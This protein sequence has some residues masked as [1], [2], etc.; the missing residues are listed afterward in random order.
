MTNQRGSKI[1]SSNPMVILGGVVIL[2]AMLLIA[3]ALALNASS[4]GIGTRI[5][6]ALNGAPVAQRAGVDLIQGTAVTITAVDGGIGDDVAYTINSTGGGEDLATTLGI[7]NITGANNILISSP[8]ALEFEDGGSA[9]NLR[10]IEGDTLT[11]DRT[12]TFNLNNT[13]S[14]LTIEASSSL[15]QDLTTDSATAAFATLTVNSLLASA[16]DS[17][18][19]GASGIAFSDLFLTSGAVISFGAGNAF[20]THS[21]G[22]LTI[23]GDMG[24]GITPS[25]VLHIKADIPGTIGDNAAGQLIIQNPSININTNVVITGYNSDISGNPDVQLWYLGSSSSSNANIIF[26]NR[27][28]ATLT[29][30]TNNTDRLTISAAGVVDVIGALTAGSVTSDTTITAFG[31]VTLVQSGTPTLKVETTATNQNA[32]IEI[33]VAAG[34]V[35]DPNLSFI[36]G[37]GTGA[38]NNMNYT[39]GYDTSANYFRLLSRDIDGLGT[40]AVVL[41]ISDG[42]NDFVFLGGISVADVI[43]I[44]QTSDPTGIVDTA[45]VYAKDVAG[46]AEVFVRDEAGNVLQISAHKGDVWYFDS[47]NDFTGRCISIDMEAALV[48]LEVLTGQDLITTTQIPPILIWESEQD[49]FAS[50]RISEQ[51]RWDAALVDILEAQI[52]WDTLEGDVEIIG[53]RPSV[54][55]IGERPSNYILEEKPQW[56]IDRLVEIALAK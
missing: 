18:A 9:F 38:A 51:L 4:A 40:V 28:N 5:D 42:T 56:L 53:D 21:T 32:N 15:N 45:F 3:L 23:D 11:A 8:Q 41:R 47:C 13:S 49:R 43:G 6:F 1:N 50:E 54:D 20:I 2:V 36:Q 35:A 12:L 30:G 34:A 19:I 37:A 7:G 10:I 17:G 44:G 25:S 27:R 33:K 24:I 55:D 16:D 22:A 48:A 26:L 31:N 52:I 29:L 14:T 46:S 39:F